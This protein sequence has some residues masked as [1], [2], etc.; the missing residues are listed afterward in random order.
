MRHDVACKDNATVCVRVLV[1]VDD[2]AIAVEAVLPVN[3]LC[4]A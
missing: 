4:Q 1:H 3:Y 2:V